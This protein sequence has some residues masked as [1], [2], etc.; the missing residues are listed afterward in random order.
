MLI[1]YGTII[2]Y[3]V[4]FDCLSPD[5][6]K[7]I[8]NKIKEEDDTTSSN[9]VNEVAHS[10]ITTIEDRLNNAEEDLEKLKSQWALWDEEIDERRGQ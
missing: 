3:K 10:T 6:K 4:T 1:N 5:V 9:V 8:I 7:Q 2:N